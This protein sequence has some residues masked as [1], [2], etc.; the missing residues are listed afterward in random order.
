MKNWRNQ[1]V[2]SWHHSMSMLWL[3]IIAMQWIS[4]TEPV[5]LNQTTTSV[6]IVLVTVS[7]IEIIFPIKL[8]FRLILE[9]IAIFYLVYRTLINYGVYVPDPWATTLSQRLQDIGTHML[10]YI[11]FALGGA[12]LL[13]LCARL[14]SS[15]GRILWF[16]GMNIVAFAA[17]D[18]FT[19]VV[20]WQEVAWIV[21]AG[22]GWLVSS[23]LRSFQL[24]YPR[25]WSYL[26]DYPFKIVINIAVVFSLVILIGV[27]MPDIRPTLK[28]PYT[29]WHE[30]NGTGKP[31]GIGK[32]GVGQSGTST[33]FSSN[34]ASSG[35][36]LDDS[37]LGGGF[38]FDYTPVMTV[39][40]DLR[41]YMRG[42]TRRVYSG[43][44][45]IDKEP[46]ERGPIAEVDVG[47][48]LESSDAPK[49][50]T[51]TLKQTINILNNNEFPVVFGAYSLATVDTLNSEN[52]GSGL[53]WGSR[54]SEMLW[55]TDKNGY[56]Y[57]VTYE[58]TSEVPIIPV[59]ELSGKTYD[60]LYSGNEIEELFLQLPDDFPERV[61]ELAEEITIDAQTPYE[62]TALLQQ[63]LQ[64]TFPYTNQPDL[65]R[66]TS[67]DLVDGFLFEMKEGYC[68]YYSTALITMARSLDIPARWV[69]G[70]APGEPAELPDNLPLQQMN[71]ISN[72][73]TITNADAHSWAEV[74]FGE[75]GWIPV[76]A[77]PGFN[78]P[79]LTQN[80]QFSETD[81]EDM[82]EEEKQPDPQLNTEDNATG[83]QGFK[84]G[85]WV[86]LAAVV[87]LLTWLTLIIWYQRF[88][89][90]FLVERLKNGRSLSP[91]Q[92][93]VAETERWVRYL[94]RKGMLKSE[95]ETL[96]EA[97]GRWSLE[98]PDVADNLSSLLV[99]FEKAKYSP[100]VIEDKDWR[101]VYTEALRLRR[102]MKARK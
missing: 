98:R 101:S 23:H 15:K 81:P 52:S 78:F 83:E 79:L 28:D 18:S 38:N 16:I 77:T 62:K 99:M 63:Y 73:Y 89:L 44:G 10:P 40:S 68:D 9:F 7:I 35:Y 71:A 97:V 72:I 45:W 49:V 8:Q 30:W 32:S 17:L 4:Y 26:L 67:P 85:H 61:R 90:R 91:D 14:V 88:K 82:E 12:A 6:W 70:Y 24:D 25:G 57:P 64:Q 1:I 54:G 50:T 86:V 47:Q 58:L 3:L 102:N 100:D 59:Q 27:N 41:T 96:R 76:E 19:S 53:Y 94:S 75:Y 13:L 33:I 5:W 36:S 55:D 69:K 22:M 92:K 84:V 56:A 93:V 20:L 60:E 29:A 2:A 87:V 31:A 66:I 43:S 21:F 37:E 42:E 51:R 34:N 48:L 46:L 11:W 95:H 65:T 80:E 39:N 74:Y